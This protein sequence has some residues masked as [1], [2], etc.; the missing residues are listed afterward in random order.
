MQRREFLRFIATAT[1][2]AWL[3]GPHSS[4]AGSGFLAELSPDAQVK[5]VLVMFK[6]HFDA[7]FIDTQAAVLQK[8]FTVY[9]PRAIE[10]ASL[11][12]GSRWARN[13]R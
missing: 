1:G 9:F 4:F 3:G 13:L 12:R 8:Y 11:M 2:S 7:G 6:C 10:V 5:R